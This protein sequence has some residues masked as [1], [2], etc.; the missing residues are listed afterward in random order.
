MLGK[1]SHKGAKVSKATRMNIK[2]FK[3]LLVCAVLFLAIAVN[4]DMTEEIKHIDLMR[5]N[6]QK[7]GLWDFFDAA[8]AKGWTMPFIYSQWYVDRLPRDQVTLA[9]SKRDFGL[10]LSQAFD[11]EGL[12]YI[13]PADSAVRETRVTR[14]LD[15][16]GW[17]RTQRSYGSV[18]LASRAESM[19][20]VQI[21]YLVAD[22]DYPT[23]KI[24][25][26]ISR[27]ID[28][29]DDER[30]RLDALN[31]ESPEKI[32]V[33][34]LTENQWMKNNMREDAWDTKMRRS[35]N[36]QQARNVYLEN[37]G[38]LPDEYQFFSIDNSTGKRPDTGTTRWNDK[39]HGMVCVRGNGDLFPHVQGASAT[40]IA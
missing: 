17:I 5:E 12:S 35:Y 2:T 7:Q 27:M 31:S 26:L 21:G 38:A 29:A 14:L 28:N 36:W 11:N 13:P 37:R 39:M 6:L 34:R 19:A 15:M 16:S 20:Y 18:I 22:L 1:V 30:F 8:L 32:R 33:L 24:D 23:D 40:P 25:A 10:A 3:T 4:A 9:Q